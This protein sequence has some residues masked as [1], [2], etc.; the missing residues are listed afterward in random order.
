[1]IYV[2]NHISNIPLCKYFNNQVTIKECLKIPSH[3]TLK[4]SLYS[5]PWI[6]THS[7]GS[8]GFYSSCTKRIMTFWL[9]EGCC[10]WILA[11]QH[12]CSQSPCFFV[13]LFCLSL[14]PFT[15]SFLFLFLFSDWIGPS[16]WE[17]SAAFLSIRNKKKKKNTCTLIQD[18]CTSLKNNVI[19]M[20]PQ[21]YI[22]VQVF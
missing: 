9:Q 16:T 10:R 7:W 6:N 21:L 4:L 17:K 22:S 13:F 3:H 12:P 8:L 5:L 19:L 18:P 15:L 1:M 20:D 11:D 2:S 14:L